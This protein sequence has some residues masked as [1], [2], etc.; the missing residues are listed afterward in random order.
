MRSVFIILLIVFV[1]TN[2]F[3]KSEAYPYSEASE[4]GK[5]LHLTDIHLD[6]LY[7][8]NSDPAEW[9][10][11]PNKSNPS[12]NTAG[13]FGALLSPCDTPYALTNATFSFFKSSVQDIDFI[14]YTG[15]FVRHDRDK[16]IPR[17]KEEVIFGHDI[18]VKYFS[19]VYD[20]KKIKSLRSGTMMNFVS[21]F[22]QKYRLHDTL[23]PG[24]N[25]VLMAIK[26]SWDP[27]GLN[28]TDDFLNGGYFR[29]DIHSTLTVLSLNSIYFLP[30][31]SKSPDCDIP[32]SPGKKQF[33]WIE[34]ELSS[35][36]AE[37]RKVYL[38][39]HIPPVN[40]TG[41]SQ[42]KTHCYSLYVDMLGRY[43]SIIY[44]H[45]TG[46]TNEDNVAFL[47][48]N[49]TSSYSLIGLGDPK[50]LSSSSNYENIVLPLYNAPSIV[51]D[52]N[53]AFRIFSYSTKDSDYGLLQDYVQYYANL[54]T[55][56]KEGNLVWE[57]EY[58][59]LDAYNMKG[60]STDN[61]L[62]TLNEFAKANSTAWKLYKLYLFTNTHVEGPYYAF[63]SKLDH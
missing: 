55:A 47:V 4:N 40:V 48:K 22:R 34:R 20:L 37:G 7:V 8:P 51:P 49:G 5:F 19:E 52:I 60:L 26:E 11:R 27:L 29:Q 57:I 12:A 33:D 21:R 38:I 24:P 18:I 45:F 41:Y 30:S 3:W 15:D 23:Q 36:V 59:V 54:T 46:H 9:C 35:A 61:W 17:T 2:E 63:L 25:K 39:Q 44:G 43:H 6:P 58:D 32:D 31:N 14:I 56:N 13:K 16:V 42:Y 50:T 62:N 10:H 1:F 28:L 53:P